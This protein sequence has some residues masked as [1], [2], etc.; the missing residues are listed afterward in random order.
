MDMYSI[1]SLF[2]WID[3]RKASY[4]VRLH[5]TNSFIH[6]RTEIIQTTNKD[7]ELNTSIYSVCVCVCS[8]FGG[9]K[10]CWTW[11]EWFVWL[12][13]Y[14]CMCAWARGRK[15]VC[16]NAKNVRITISSSVKNI[17]WLL[18]FYYVYSFYLFHSFG[19]RC[20][21]VRVYIC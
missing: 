1:F 7:N 3:I 10:L 17:E 20:L 21:F 6:S 4:R 18:C 9:D 12:S 5:F 19:S 11:N 14:V 16:T 2:G 15:S 8:A 13:V